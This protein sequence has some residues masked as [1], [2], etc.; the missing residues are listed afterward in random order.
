LEGQSE[1]LIQTFG[2]MGDSMKPSTKR[3]RITERQ[4]KGLRTKLEKWGE[5]LPAQER[6]LLASILERAERLGLTEA[7][8]PK[9]GIKVIGLTETTFA[10]GQSPL[11]RCAKWIRRA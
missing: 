8:L 3:P 10:P 1:K 4:I 11:V 7:P 6:K 5:T 9:G 2:Q